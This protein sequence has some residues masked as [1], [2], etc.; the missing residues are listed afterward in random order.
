M[1]FVLFTSCCLHIMKS[2]QGSGLC[3]CF[4][5]QLIFVLWPKCCTFFFLSSFIHHISRKT[6]TCH[7]G[8]TRRLKK[9]LL[10]SWI[11]LVSFCQKNDEV[12]VFVCVLIKARA[13]G[14]LLLFQKLQVLAQGAAP[15]GDLSEEVD[16]VQS[17]SVRLPGEEEGY[18]AD[19]ESNPEDMARQEEGRSHTQ[20]RIYTASPLTCLLLQ[21]ENRLSSERSFCCRNPLNHSALRLAPT[22]FCW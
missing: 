14:L 19:S 18:D 20:P 3:A 2:W 7:A 10:L 5:G 12:D 9:S 15:A 6:T 1:F 17:C 16:E 4:S 8:F 22:C 21:I 11:F 13:V